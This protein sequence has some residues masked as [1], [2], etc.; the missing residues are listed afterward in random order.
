VRAFVRFRLA[1]GAVF[2]LLPGDLVGRS[3]SAGLPLDDARVSEAHAMVSL[4]GGELKLLALRGRFAVE[5]R[6]V[7]ELTLAA[8]QRVELARD[9]WLSVES[10]ELPDEV[11]GL[12]GDGLARQVLA[13]VCSLL[14]APRP[15]LLAGY[16]GEAPAHIWS[17][18]DGWRVSLEQAAPRALGPGDEIVVRGRRF[19]AVAVPLMQAD[20][21]AT[22]GQGAVDAPLH[23]VVRWDSVHCLRDGTP[24]QVLAGLPARIISELSAL[25]GSVDWEVL[26]RELWSGEDD[27]LALRRRL[28]VALARLRE[29]LRAARIRTDLVA[30]DGAGHIELRLSAHDRIDDQQ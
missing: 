25:G 16:R 11:L 30:A 1:D 13:P 20:G 10:V 17:T 22:H 23:L 24:T 29:K 26:A 27:R 15:A 8:G 4:R 14:V 19:R 9:L 5:G 7:T 28:D 12:E 18:G 21:Q 2:D 3:W 6:P